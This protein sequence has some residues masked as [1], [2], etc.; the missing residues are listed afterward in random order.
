MSHRSDDGKG[1]DGEGVVVRLLFRI[2]EGDERFALLRLVLVALKHG[3]EVLED[4]SVE[5]GQR[6]EVTLVPLR[7]ARRVFGFNQQI[8]GGL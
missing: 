4:V 2:E 8:M 7:G 6:R 3:D 5:P 1:T